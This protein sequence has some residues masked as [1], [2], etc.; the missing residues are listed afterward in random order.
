MR[1]GNASAAAREIEFAAALVL[2]ASLNFAA[3]ACKRLDIPSLRDASVGRTCSLPLRDFIAPRITL[4]YSDSQSAMVG[5]AL[6]TLSFSG[7]PAKTPETNGPA[8][9]SR[10]SVPNLR[11]TKSARDSSGAGAGWERRKGS[12]KTRILEL[13]LRREVVTSAG[14][15]MGARSSLPFRRI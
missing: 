15:D 3:R 8:R 7:S 1:Q 12:L 2:R 10:I 9:Y 4:P 13:T 11:R 14:G 5:N 6:R